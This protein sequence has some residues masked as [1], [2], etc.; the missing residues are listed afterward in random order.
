[1]WSKELGPTFTTA[2]FVW[3]ALRQLFNYF[4]GVVPFRKWSEKLLGSLNPSVTISFPEFLEGRYKRSAVFT[5]IESY[6]SATCGGSARCLRAEPGKGKSGIVFSMDAGQEV[7]DHFEGVS[8][9]WSFSVVKGKDRDWQ[10]R[11]YT[12]SFR[13]RHR[14]LVVD[15][16]LKFVMDQGK[17]MAAA[18]R[19]RRLFT[20]SSRDDRHGRLWNSVPFE[21]PATFQTL[22]MDPLKKAELVNDLLSF[23]ESKEYYTRVGKAWKRGYL[24]YGPP[25]TGKS[26]LIAAMAN[27]LE[28]D[29]YDL[30][31]TAVKDNSSLR[32][33]LIEMTSKSIVVVE[34]IDCSLDL[35][36]KRKTKKGEEKDLSDS[37]SDSC[38]AE[39]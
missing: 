36:G 34:D 7:M 39:Q 22:A 2:I 20:N 25:G 1:M 17:E 19:Q 9:S 5:G 18:R 4:D 26:S 12:L 15:K 23:R 33:L 14:R 37:D 24:L 29:V 8:L 10:R 38:Y 6:L 35:T 11:G 27:L 13:R 30:E 3:M 28:Y 32:G 31:L 21:H 16:Y